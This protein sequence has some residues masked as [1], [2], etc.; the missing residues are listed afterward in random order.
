MPWGKCVQFYFVGLFFNNFLISAMGGDFF[1]MVDIRRFSRKGTVAVSTVFIDRFMGLLVLSGLALAVSP[2]ILLTW[3]FQKYF[4]LP[5]VFLIIAWL[6]A[7]FFLFNKHFAR[8]FAWFIQKLIPDKIVTK[9]KAIYNQIHDFGRRKK[10]FWRIVFISIFIQSARIVTHYL[11]ALS[12]GVSVFP[13]YFFLII[14]IIAIIASLP[15]SLGGIGLREQT[16]VVLFGLIGMTAVQAF[17]V[18]FLAYL[19][20]IGSSLPGGI[21]FIGRKKIEPVKKQLL[22]TD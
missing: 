18:E 17:S 13:I 14:P 2:L 12:L 1:R 16:G 5:M 15:V 3:G 7:L 20:A 4:W 9:A 21:I 10:L 6:F 22:Q 11:L 19:V 8:P